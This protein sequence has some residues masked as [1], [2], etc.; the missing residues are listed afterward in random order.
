[1][2]TNVK[3]NKVNDVIDNKLKF[4]GRNIIANYPARDP[5]P[6][7]NISLGDSKKSKQTLNSG[8]TCLWDIGYTNNMISCKHINHYNTKL[9]TINVKYITG[10]GLYKPPHDVKVP[11]RIPEFYSRKF[12]THCFHV[13]KYEVMSGSAMT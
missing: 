4:D 2:I 7:V 13:K 12:I 5:L 10:A 6:I 9:R 1:M 3:M 8:L 11:F